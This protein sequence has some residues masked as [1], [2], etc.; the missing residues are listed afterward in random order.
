MRISGGGE[1]FGKSRNGG[2]DAF[3]I[4][5]KKISLTSDG[6]SALGSLVEERSHSVAL[7]KRKDKQLIKQKVKQKD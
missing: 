2:D 6:Q 1:P 4:S 7:T 3:L 5:D